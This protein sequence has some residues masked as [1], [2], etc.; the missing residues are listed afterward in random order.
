[1][2]AAVD[3]T[4]LLQY[5]HYVQVQP[6]DWLL[7]LHSMCCMAHCGSHVGRHQHQHTL[8]T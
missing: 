3:H 8:G 5:V 2:T 1:V 7:M 4:M 6:K